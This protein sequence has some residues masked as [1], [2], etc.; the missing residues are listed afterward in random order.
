METT[1]Q[2]ISPRELERLLQEGVLVI[3]VR[4]PLEQATAC[5]EGT[6][7][8]DDALYEELS[9][10]DRSTPIA[11]HCHHG[12]RSQGAAEHFASLGF[13]TLYNLAGGIDAW[14]VEVDPRVR[15]Y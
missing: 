9:A 4:T 6:R 2:Q 11:F 5:I 15:R 3:D 13:T 1:I 8:L 7:L 10:L 12:M 14:S